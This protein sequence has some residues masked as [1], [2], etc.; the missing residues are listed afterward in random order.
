LLDGDSY[1]NVGTGSTVVL[2]N[3]TQDGQG[4]N[5]YYPLVTVSGAL[6]LDKGA[7]LRGRTNTTGNAGG[8][9]TQ[10]GA[11]V[12]MNG[13][14]VIEDCHSAS[15][16]GGVYL[17]GA[18]MNTSFTMTGGTI[19]NCSADFGGGVSAY[20]AYVTI[21]MNGGTIEN[22][23]AS[24]NGGGGGIALA[25]NAKLQ[26][27]G[28]A[29][30]TTTNTTPPMGWGLYYDYWGGPYITPDPTGTEIL[31]FFMPQVNPVMQEPG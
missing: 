3:I 1:F 26:L 14:A 29:M 28:A 17:N 5:G 13:L 25:S 21:D 31:D 24:S 7:T 12:V 22:C 16:G 2:Q 8:I 9:A 4:L 18:D 11:T 30:I 10:D 20:G 15:N 23:E 19:R 6:S 27:S